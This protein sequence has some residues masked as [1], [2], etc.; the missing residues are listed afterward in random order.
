[1]HATRPQADA[2]TALTIPDI[3]LE[4]A[5]AAARGGG[6]AGRFYYEVS[7]DLGGALVVTITHLSDG[8]TRTV[9]FVAEDA[10]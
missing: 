4:V 9:R 7:T 5:A 6:E 10:R 8:A 3:A 2:P 1:M